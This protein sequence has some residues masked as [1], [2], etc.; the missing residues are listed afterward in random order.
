MNIDGVKRALALF[1]PPIDPALLV[2]AA[3]QGI[4]LSTVLAQLNQ[5]KPHY[6]FRVWIQK[7]ADL[8]NEVKSF[9]GA[10]L[11]AL[12]KK[13]AEELSRL[14]QGHELELLKLTTKIREEQIK[15]AEENIVALEASRAIAE[16]RQ[17][18]YSRRQFMIGP[19]KA[20]KSLNIASGSLDIAAGAMNTVA[21][22]LGAIPQ[23][24]LTLPP[25]GE[26]GG[27]H[28]NSIFQA[29]AAGFGTAATAT[30]LSASLAET[31]GSYQRRQEDWDLQEDQAKLEVAQINQQIT[32]AQVRLEIA[33]KELSNHEVQMEQS[34][35]VQTFLQ[36][37]FT[38][39]ELYRWMAGELQKTYRQSYNLAYDVSK[40]AEATF[41]F[42]L[43]TPDASFIQF[44]YMESVYKGLLAGEKLGNDIKRMDIAYLQRDKREF[45][46]TKPI[47]LAQLNPTALQDLRAKG[48]CEFSLPEVLFDLD[49]PGQYFRR[50]RAVRLTIPCVTG[51][52]TSVSAKLSLLNSAIRT[53]STANA[54]DPEDYPY[55]GFNDERF[56][57]NFGG[58]QSIATSTAQDDAGL[59]ELNFKD[60]RYLPF[61]GQGVVST[62][63]LELPQGARQFDYHS[64]SD[65]VVNVSYTARDAG[66]TLTSAVNASLEMGLNNL[67]EMIVQEGS[68][69][70]RVFSMKREFPDALHQLL[71]SGSATIKI[72]PEH[73]PY[74]L[75]DKGYELTHLIPPGSN[76]GLILTHVVTR[77]ELT[78]EPRLKIEL[79]GS[80]TTPQNQFVNFSEGDL[81][82][83]RTASLTRDREILEVVSGWQPEEWMLTREDVGVNDVDDILFELKYMVEA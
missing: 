32:A 65:V 55:K 68:G 13:D 63:R 5:P 57:H 71:S 37:K 25:A 81:P 74:L 52:Y 58:I 66:G 38:N 19:E 54:T 27:Q 46:I 18:N 75:R 24:H 73:F 70:A 50:I 34:E 78:T 43:G 47:S 40:T 30:R 6:R 62:W 48:W 17:Q 9:G 83:V 59:F 51:P 7:A 2:K 56:A 1:E 82:N 22:A 72:L 12:E 77:G 10:L 53:K 67:L 28:L 33:K 61:E 44:N 31:Q 35:E 80:T 64:I 21:G 3:A 15:E 45:E 29:I 49:F 42:E 41:Q 39:Q 79:V 69:L 36:D 20:A 26:F 8:V 76:P 4:D 60:D 16:Q 23:L 11:S 14:R